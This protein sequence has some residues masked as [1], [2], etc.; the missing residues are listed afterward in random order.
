MTLYYKEKEVLKYL[1]SVGGKAQAHAITYN[2]FC[3]Y[4]D[5]AEKV[6][7]ALRAKKLIKGYWE[8]ELTE[9]GYKYLL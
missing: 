3:G 1:K 8:I 5:W 2:C 9:E 6:I 4:K 7:S